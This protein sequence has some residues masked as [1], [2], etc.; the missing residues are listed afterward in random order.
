MSDLLSQRDKNGFHA[1]SEMHLAS[2]VP[3][4]GPFN[5]TTTALL[6][7][8]TFGTIGFFIGKIIGGLGDDWKKNR[9]ERFATF[10]KWFGAASFGL[11]AA[12]VAIRQSRESKAQ[13]EYLAKHSIEVELKNE[14]LASALSK[15]PLI[16]A[17]K[18]LAD[19]S[20]SPLQQ[21]HDIDLQGQ[22]S[23]K[24]SLEKSQ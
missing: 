10:G 6:S 12:S 1:N 3:D 17:S 11:L 14:A 4:T 21:L 24:Q 20:D 22:V 23:T 19:S 16:D 13:A 5:E 8:G 9:H 15:T 2:R 18:T 7:M